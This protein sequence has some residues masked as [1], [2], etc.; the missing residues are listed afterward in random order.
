[1]DNKITYTVT[2]QDLLS[3]KLQSMNMQADKLDGG[4][5][6]LMG[7]INGVGAAVGI[8]F[9]VQQIS[10]FVGKVI[11]AGTTVENA[12]TG[13]TTLLGDSA[14]ATEVVKN[15]MIDATKT[16]FAFEGLLSANKAL[17]GAGIEAGRAR[18]DVLNLANAIAATGGGDAE[19]QQMVVNMQQIS[20]TGKATAM[21]IKQFAFAGVNIYKVLAEATGKPIE[22]VKEMEVSYDML[23][24]ALAKA[25][26]KG[27]I[28]FN[29]LE[30]MADNTS[31]KISNVGDALF[32]SFVDIF[33]KIKPMVDGAL[34]YI[35]NSIGDF[36]GTMNASMDAII[37]YLKPLAEPI[38]FLIDKFKAGFEKLSSVLSQFSVQG[39]S[40]LVMLRE[41]L[42]GLIYYWGYMYD[43]LFSFLS[44][45]VDVFHTVYVL[46]EKLGIIWVIAKAFSIVWEIIKGIGTA[47]KWIYENTLKPIF[48]A[49]SWAYRQ[50]KDLLGIKDTKFTATVVKKEETQT[51]G[52]L[53]PSKITPLS[54]STAAKGKSTAGVQANKAVTINIQIGSLIHDF[55]IST[56]NLT[57]SSQKIHDKIVEVLTG[58]VND[59]QLIAGN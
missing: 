24:F 35:S 54:T 2:A 40:V 11:D 32:Q 12:T 29:G 42:S 34:G 47:I 31:V 27:G 51:S 46:L 1:M 59:S 16:P 30:N 58:A 21:D 23:S 20:N 13:L 4:M 18:Q 10:N 53:S 14:K 25:H 26:E 37:E 33:D 7:T 52:S 8:A 41:A 19:L 9:G 15:T 43:A 3:G 57:E 36:K 38:M 28:Y 17:I 22:K 45:V 55:K 6:K 49:V 48:D 5:S 56:T 44:I 39:V 50:L